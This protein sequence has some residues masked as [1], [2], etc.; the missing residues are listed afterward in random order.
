MDYFGYQSEA[1]GA[2]WGLFRSLGEITPAQR[3][4]MYSGSEY[5]HTLETVSAALNGSIPTDRESVRNFNLWGYECACAANDFKSRLNRVKKEL[6][7]VDVSSESDSSL[8]VGYGDI[9]DREL[10]AK[11]DLFEDLVDSMTFE[12]NI[13]TLLNIRSKYIVECGVDVVGVLRSALRGIPDAVN[14]MRSLVKD[15]LLKDLYIQLCEESQDGA[16]LRRL[17]AIV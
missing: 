14:E 16:L 15:S 7:I 9:S 11:D 4:S 6:N 17:E 2:V 10:K 12:D 3:E 1:S 5:A 13:K 8:Q